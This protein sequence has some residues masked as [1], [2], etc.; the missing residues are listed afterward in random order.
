MGRINQQD[1]PPLDSPPLDSHEQ[2]M[3]RLR[4]SLREAIGYWEPR[5][6]VY[7]LVLAVIG[8][9]S[10]WTELIEL[11]GDGWWRGL[12]TLLVLAVFCLL[13]NLCYCLAYI[14]EFALQAS[15]WA[16]GWRRWRWALFAGGTLF[17]SGLACQAL[18]MPHGM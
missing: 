9:G 3:R 2:A 16:A 8:I 18:W 11:A 7:N 17:A 5:R 4:A 1:A 14:P 13:A 10:S 6:L 15:I 12:G